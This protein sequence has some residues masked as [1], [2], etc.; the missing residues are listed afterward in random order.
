MLSI[1]AH[2]AV[3]LK[4]VACVLV[5]L[6]VVAPM[7]A[8]ATPLNL[9]QHH[10][11]DVTTHFTTVN[12]SLNGDGITGTLTAEGYPDQFDENNQ[13]VG[14]PYQY[15]YLTMTL[16]KT[17]HAIVSGSV[18]ID[19]ETDGSPHFLGTNTTHLLT[20]NIT[21]FGFADP[22]LG[23]L[24]AG[25]LFEFKLDVTGG[26]LAPAYYTSGKGGIILNIQ[27]GS[28]ASNFTGVF[29][30]PFDNGGNGYSDTFP[31]PVPEPSTAV[32]L[33]LGFIPLARHLR[34]RRRSLLKS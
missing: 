12:Y 34:R 9:T 30:A 8:Q 7:R 19:G 28:G 1:E 18:L 16:N 33:A 32:L 31:M 27:N 22:P 20:G 3:S 26:V 29:T 4:L 2:R 11:G 6:F 5:A 25:N 24:G 10:F 15:F 17:T 23:S 21:A 14:G 13:N